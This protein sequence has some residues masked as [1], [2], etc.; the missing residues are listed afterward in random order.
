V[1]DLKV[2]PEMGF[3]SSMIACAVSNSGAPEMLPPARD[4]KLKQGLSLDFIRAEGKQ[5]ELRTAEH[6]TCSRVAGMR[7]SHGNELQLVTYRMRSAAGG[8]V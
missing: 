5:Y 8:C 7:R 4:R 3:G 2:V 1:L 6:S